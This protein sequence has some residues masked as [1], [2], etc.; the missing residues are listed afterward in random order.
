MSAVDFQ[1]WAT[2]DLVMKLGGR[3]FTVQPPS[4]EAAKQCLAA[5]VYAEAA[6]F[7]GEVP[8]EVQE[9]VEE[10]KGDTDDHPG[11]REAYSEMIEAGVDEHTIAR[12]GTY[13]IFF[14]ARGKRYA[15][16]LAALLWMPRD[17]GAKA[18]G[19]A[20]P[21]GSRPPR[22]GRRTGSASRT[23]KAGSRPTGK[24]RKR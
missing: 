23:D 2:P 8:D 19:G 14:W 6:I 17:L 13:S 22:T 18:A 11:L 16:G 3:A 24:S 9:I 10:L 1:Q 20:S 7:G 15:D 4:V 21:K 5:A 12:M